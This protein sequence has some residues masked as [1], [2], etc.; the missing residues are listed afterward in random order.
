M[1]RTAVVLEDEEDIRSLIT[2]VLSGAGYE[3]FETANGLDA[4]EL[5]S[6]HNPDLTTLDVNVPG[7]DGFEAARRIRAVSDTYVIMISAF[8]EEADA[9]RGRLAGADEYLGKPF[10]PR[11]LRARLEMVPDRRRAAD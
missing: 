9:E 1:Q 3:V 4:V 6:T 10:R 2:A 11:E 5:V 8:V 7:I